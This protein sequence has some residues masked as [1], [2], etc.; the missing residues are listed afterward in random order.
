M[1]E[2]KVR[3]RSETKA[4]P[5][6]MT[7]T[8]EQQRAKRA[9]DAAK[10]GK[11]VRSYKRRAGSDSAPSSS[12]CASSSSDAIRPEPPPPSSVEGSID[13]IGITDE[14]VSVIRHIRQIKA[15][16]AA[17]DRTLLRER[18]HQ[19]TVSPSHRACTVSC[20]ISCRRAVKHVASAAARQHALAGVQI[21][22]A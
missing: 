14:E 22:R 2:T 3:P 15:E 7:W 4:R 11:T 17:K 13:G 16:N 12:G 9:E 5:S 19:V 21:L 8:A 18:T 20:H 1:N 6:G 10:E